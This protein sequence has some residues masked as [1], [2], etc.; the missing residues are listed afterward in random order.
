MIK[1][2]LG[3]VKYRTAKLLPFAQVINYAF[4][5]AAVWIWLFDLFGSILRR[6]VAVRE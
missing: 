6:L 2:P 5:I 4:Q 1:A 3:A